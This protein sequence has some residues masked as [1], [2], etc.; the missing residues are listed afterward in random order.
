MREAG[1]PRGIPP[2]F[3][4][5][6]KEGPPCSPARSSSK[7]FTAASASTKRATPAA[8]PMSSCPAP[9]ASP[10]VDE[11]GQE[12]V[13]DQAHLRRV[14]RLSLHVRGHPSSNQR[15]RPGETSAWKWTATT[16]PFPDRTASPT[17]HGSARDARS[18]VSHAAQQLVWPPRHARSPTSS[19]A[20]HH[21]RPN[22]L[23]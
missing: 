23:R 22:G 12:V 10:H 1:S 14:L 21:P 16:S 7:T 8:A 13:V 20:A 9:S 5:S 3:P 6:T 15:L 19:S 17:P 18:P 11:D 2:L 4:C